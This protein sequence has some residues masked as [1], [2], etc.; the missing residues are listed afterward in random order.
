[1]SYTVS[2]SRE[3]IKTLKKVDHKLENRMIK[4]LRSLEDNPKGKGK[5]FK[6]CAGLYSLRVGSFRIL[7]I[8]NEEEHHAYVV[9]IRARGQAYR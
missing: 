8:I 4:K 1:M 5:A 3:A 2:L 9:A 6:S 7:Y